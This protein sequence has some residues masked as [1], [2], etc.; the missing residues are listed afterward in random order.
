MTIRAGLACAR[1]LSLSQGWPPSAPSSRRR[2]RD[3]AWDRALPH[4]SRLP[5]RFAGSAVAAD[6]LGHG[7]RCCRLR[8][9]AGIEAGTTFERVACWW[10][11]A[12]AHA[13]CGPIRILALHT[14]LPTERRTAIGVF[15]APDGAPTSPS[16]VATSLRS[17]R[18]GSVPHARVRGR[19]GLHRRRY[20]RCQGNRCCQRSPSGAVVAAL[21]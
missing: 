10:G 6:R 16:A 11:E 7:R 1:A 18:R 21:L 20:P 19:T 14:L 8:D 17:R 13:Y 5:C 15:A 9:S 4:A 2:K 3:Q 12:T